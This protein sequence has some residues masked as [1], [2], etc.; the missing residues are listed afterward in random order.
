MTIKRRITKLE[1]VG[2]SDTFTYSIF[3]KDE[4]SVIRDEGRHVCKP[5]GHAII[6]KAGCKP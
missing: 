3:Y 4:F 6:L 2:N 5:T 1:E